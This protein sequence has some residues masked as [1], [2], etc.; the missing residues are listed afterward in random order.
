MGPGELL[1]GAVRPPLWAPSR[2]LRPCGQLAR[3]VILAPEPPSPSGPA[4]PRTSPLGAS[5]ADAACF[6]E[7]ECREK[8]GQGDGVLSESANGP[9]DADSE[10]VGP[11]RRMVSRSWGATQSRCDRLTGSQEPEGEQAHHQP[12]RQGPPDPC[13][14]APQSHHTPLSSL[15]TLLE[16]ACEARVPG[17]QS[18]GCTVPGLDTRNGSGL[19]RRGSGHCGTRPGTK[20]PGRP[21]D[22][23]E[24]LTAHLLPPWPASASA[25]CGDPA[26]RWT[27]RVCPDL[28]HGLAGV[29][30]CPGGP[31]TW[32]PQSRGPEDADLTWKER[33]V[34]LASG[35]RASWSLVRQGV[36]QRCHFPAELRAGAGGPFGL[37][38]P[39]RGEYPPEALGGPE[40]PQAQREVPRPSSLHPPHLPATSVGRSHA[41]SQFTSRA[42]TLWPP[43]PGPEHD[44]AISQTGQ[45]G[46]GSTLWA[47]SSGACVTSRA[48]LGAPS[49]R[50]GPGDPDVQCGETTARTVDTG[51]RGHGQGP[52]RGRMV[53]PRRQRGKTSPFL[54]LEE[55]ELALGW[56]LAGE[57]VNRGSQ[58]S[59]S[60][61]PPP[62]A[63]PAA[64]QASRLLAQN[65]APGTL[66][67]GI[68]LPGAWQTQAQRPEHLPGLQ[69]PQGPN[70]PCHKVYPWHSLGKVGRVG[71]RGG[72]PGTLLDRRKEGECSRAQ[73]DSSPALGHSPQSTGSLWS[74][75]VPRGRSSA[76]TSA[77]MQLDAQS[78]CLEAGRPTARGRVAST[79][80]AP[81][82]SPRNGERSQSEC[83][84]RPEGAV[85]KAGELGAS[86]GPGSAYRGDLVPAGP[87][88]PET[89]HPAFHSPGGLMLQTQCP[90]PTSSPSAPPGSTATL[91]FGHLSTGLPRVFPRAAL[92][93]GPVQELG[94][95]T[96]GL[97]PATS[98]AAS[99]CDGPETE[100][101]LRR[102]PQG[103][104]PGLPGPG[105]LALSGCQE[106]PHHPHVQHVP[107]TWRE[108]MAQPALLT[109]RRAKLRA[110]RRG[111][112]GTEGVL[113]P[114]GQAQA[115]TQPQFAQGPLEP[116]FQE[117]WA[118]DLTHTSPSIISGRLGAI[119]KPE[120]RAAKNSAPGRKAAAAG[121]SGTGKRTS[122][123]GASGCPPP[124]TLLWQRPGLS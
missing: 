63:R 36:R 62:P 25:Q 106:E 1:A 58:A 41:E 48:W 104:A 70:W 38:S 28:W 37:L 16:K 105:N 44:S 57:P 72:R 7:E 89:V 43:A 8:V 10:D 80:R 50:P 111:A 71:I 107:T 4:G 82:L 122:H 33:R 17:G 3:L 115:P 55:G 99:F 110:E 19:E 23:G 121:L 120:A 34:A 88:Y 49:R 119:P 47:L 108:E 124:L 26:G 9:P 73:T 116:E 6:L 14:G 65:G 79:G 15:V 114:L 60:A 35:P 101:N 21:Q 95:P 2:G 100:R 56:R 69:S 77:R 87:S 102:G 42:G 18:S 51:G 91:R 61:T 46:T 45:A 81:A 92:E 112:E 117:D 31:G 54:D 94:K 11:L 86:W 90:T 118:V 5:R 40:A 68:I 123:E 109:T 13:P 76:G 53:A 64:A 39:E 67:G 83:P 24:G 103:A 113:V 85:R 93:A 66:A 59:P 30:V 52:E 84:P 97:S 78:P 32:G 20:R 75:L 29:R 96:K 74:L 22:R 12:S 98:R 27:G